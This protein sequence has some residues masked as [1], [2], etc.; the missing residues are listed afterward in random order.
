MSAFVIGAGL[1]VAFAAALGVTLCR[2]AKQ[3]DARIEALLRELTDE[4][5]AVIR[6]AVREPVRATGDVLV[7][8]P[9]RFAPNG[10]V[11]RH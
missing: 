1:I 3:A 11:I 7:F 6:E 5:I 4:D 10:E 9:E 2:A 8:V